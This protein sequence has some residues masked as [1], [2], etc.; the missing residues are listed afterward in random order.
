M[1][2]RSASLCQR[3]NIRSR[4]KGWR[5]LQVRGNRDRS[6]QKDAGSVGDYRPMRKRGEATRPPSGDDDGSAP[7]RSLELDLHGL[8]PC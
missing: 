7:V 3:L 8:R 5:E 2:Q 6:A 1:G 4:L